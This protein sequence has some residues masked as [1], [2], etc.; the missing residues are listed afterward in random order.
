MKK[1][2]IITSLTALAAFCLCVAAQAQGPIV[3]S[4]KD[5]YS[6]GETAMFQQPAFSRTSSWILASLSPTITATSVPDIAWADVP[7]D[8][9]GDAE[10]DYVVA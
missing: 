2:F 9:S 3:V 1:S 10:V 4:D 7:A 6:P 8:A 5:D